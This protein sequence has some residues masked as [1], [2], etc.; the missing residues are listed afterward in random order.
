MAPS[1]L[2]GDGYRP[3]SVYVLGGRKPAA[4]VEREVVTRHDREYNIPS[5][6]TVRVDIGFSSMSLMVKSCREQNGFP[7]NERKGN[8]QV[9]R[10]HQQGARIVITIITEAEFSHSTMRLKLQGIIILD[11]SIS[12]HFRGISACEKLA[13]I[14]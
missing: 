11:R 3:R 7:R 8:S 14:F 13:I 6:K 2:V 9:E 12:P 10:E 5:T 4:V 1:S